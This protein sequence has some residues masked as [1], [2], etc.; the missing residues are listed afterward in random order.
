[1]TAIQ[2]SRAPQA[3]MDRFQEVLGSSIFTSEL[4][5]RESVDYPLPCPELWVQCRLNLNRHWRALNISEVLGVIHPAN[6]A[7]VINDYT[8][9][10]QVYS[11]TQRT[12]YDVGILIK[13]PA[14]FP[15]VHALD[16]RALLDDEWMQ[17]RIELYRGALLDV[18]PRYAPDGAFIHEIYIENSQADIFEIPE[19]GRFAHATVTFSVFQDVLINTW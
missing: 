9:G 16:G 1:M 18:V 4:L 19:V 13:A 8:G 5:A 7:D 2:I 11:R 15:E 17:R 3:A 10:N 6:S 14:A 12:P